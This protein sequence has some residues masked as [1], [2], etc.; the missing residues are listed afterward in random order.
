MDK[1]IQFFDDSKKTTHL[2][3]GT[4]GISESP[5]F[6]ES[7]GTNPKKIEFTAKKVIGEKLD[8]FV[9]LT[10]FPLKT[11]FR[12]LFF[13]KVTAELKSSCSI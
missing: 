1:K 6:S 11:A 2:Q 10:I 9:N 12:T 5:E 3:R 7:F 4:Y 13:V 8:F